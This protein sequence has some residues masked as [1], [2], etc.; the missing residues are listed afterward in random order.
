M[1][2]RRDH[3]ITMIQGEFFVW[4][5]RPIFL[6]AVFAMSNELM[7]DCACVLACISGYNVIR[8]KQQYLMDKK[9]IIWYK[10]TY[11]IQVKQLCRPRSFYIR[12]TTHCYIHMQCIQFTLR[13]TGFEAHSTVVAILHFC[14]PLYGRV[15]LCIQSKSHL[16]CCYIPRGRQSGQ[17][18]FW[19]H[20]HH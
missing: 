1:P 8:N 19:Q 3:I 18:S 12:F 9:A 4:G 20:S 11:L 15:N 14:F 2:H 7:K 5:L 6:C 13:V 10:E 17:N 16:C